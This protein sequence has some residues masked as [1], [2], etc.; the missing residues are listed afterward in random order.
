MNNG[1]PDLVDHLK[2]L[3]G[4]NYASET[5]LF[6]TLY[7]IGVSLPKGYRSGGRNKELSRKEANRYIEYK[8]LYEV[9]PN[10]KKKRAVTIT[11]VR[12]PPIPKEDGRGSKGRY[13]DYLRPLIVKT[14]MDHSFRGTK[15]ELFDSWGVYDKYRE[16]Q[17]R[18]GLFNP[19]KGHSFNPWSI[20]K[21]I[22]PGEAKY[23]QLISFK[24]RDSLETA[25]NSLGK[26]GVIEWS[27]YTR[28]A[29]IIKTTEF[30]DSVE[31]LKTWKEY[32]KDCNDRLELITQLSEE[33]NCV[34]SSKL[35]QAGLNVSQSTYDAWSQLYYG[36]NGEQLPDEQATAEQEI[37]YENYQEFIRQLTIYECSSSKTFCSP[38]A[39]PNKY[40]IFTDWTYRRRYNDLDKTWKRQLLGWEQVRQE[41]YFKMIDERRAIT[42]LEQY[43]PELAFELACEYI[44]YMDEHMDR[45]KLYYPQNYTSDFEGIISSDGSMRLFPLS[46]SGS[47][48]NLHKKLKRLFNLYYFKKDDHL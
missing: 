6:D 3:E 35:F 27:K 10:C 41:L 1:D 34:L 37:M 39:I 45:E 47:A 21:D 12:D 29:P 48:A 24:E 32:T 11:K 18:N 15:T 23:Y 40:N 9:D 26:E 22:R 31:R 4:N 28:Y 36:S 43:S 38:E 46:T 19:N 20:T 42:Y 17:I 13:A 7:E 33:Q 14:A 25:L 44:L 8:P 5:A 30:I 2:S 16:E